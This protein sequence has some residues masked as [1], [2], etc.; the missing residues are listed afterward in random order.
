MR[1]PKRRCRRLA[2][3]ATL[4]LGILALPAQA[5]PGNGGPPDHAGGARAQPERGP[6]ARHE[7]RH[8]ERRHADREG[9]EAG[10]RRD[11][12]RLEEALI[13]GVFHR[14]RDAFAGD[15]RVSLPPGI[16]QNLARG[17]PLPPG[18]AKRLDAGIRRD[19]PHYDGHEWRR[20]G[21]DVVL[22]DITRDIIRAVIRDVLD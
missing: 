3:V 7:P 17:K 2:T 20:V 15:E 6:A 12:P 8:G 21:S 19:L 1:V 22:V 4:M 13:R 10:H 9:G 11:A 18:I 16:R 14:H 5:A